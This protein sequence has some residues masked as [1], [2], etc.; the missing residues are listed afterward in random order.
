M[1]AANQFLD[2]GSHGVGKTNPSRLIDMGRFMQRV[3]LPVV[4]YTDQKDT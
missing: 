3:D 1:I 2:D 4:K